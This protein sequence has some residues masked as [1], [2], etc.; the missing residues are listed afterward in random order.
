MTYKLVRELKAGDVINLNGYMR[1]DSIQH[2]TF[3]PSKLTLTD[4]DTFAS[5]DQEFSPTKNVEVKELAQ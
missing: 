5:F 1:I 2:V 4:L 3:Q